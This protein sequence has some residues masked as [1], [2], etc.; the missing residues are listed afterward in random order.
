METRLRIVTPQQL[1]HGFNVMWQNDEIETFYYVVV[2]K[3]PNG[4]Y[5]VKEP[6]IFG[7]G[8]FVNNALKQLTIP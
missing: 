7:S 4:N 5:E 1:V 6:E 2:R 8:H 3:L